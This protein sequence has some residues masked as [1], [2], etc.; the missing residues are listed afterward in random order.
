VNSKWIRGRGSLV[1]F[2]CAEKEKEKGKWVKRE[3]MGRNT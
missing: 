1:I 2:M 3:K